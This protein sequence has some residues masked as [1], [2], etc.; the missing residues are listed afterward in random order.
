VLEHSLL[1]F[2]HPPGGHGT[3]EGDQEHGTIAASR[4]HWVGTVW[5]VRTVVSPVLQPFSF[6]PDSTMLY[7]VRTEPTPQCDSG[8][9]VVTTQQQCTASRVHRP[10]Q[11]P[12]CGP[13]L[14]QHGVLW[15]LGMPY[16][17]RR[18]PHFTVDATRGPRRE[19]RNQGKQA[20]SAGIGPQ[21]LAVLLQP[22][23]PSETEYE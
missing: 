3:I 6:V 17:A 9:V 8:A 22:S 15:P 5:V 4:E 2:F 21:Q 7:V 11:L 13:L 16:P 19:S 18:T 14:V 23:Q 10:Q 12:S 20:H 1:Q